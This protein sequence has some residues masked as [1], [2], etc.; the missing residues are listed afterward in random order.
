MQRLKF[1]AGV[2]SFIPVA[3]SYQAGSSAVDT[4]GSGRIA[5]RVV[6]ALTRT[7][8]ANA[9]VKLLPPTVLLPPGATVGR[10]GKMI[11]AGGAVVDVPR[12][13]VALSLR[14]GPD[15]SFEFKDVAPGLYE[16]DA[17]GDAYL[18][19][20]Q[21]TPTG[22]GTALNLPR[23]GTVGAV[24]VRLYKAA[25]IEGTLRHASGGPAVGLVVEAVQVS[26]TGTGPTL[27]GAGS[28]ATDD[29][30]AYRLWPLPPGR[31]LV[32]MSKRRPLVARGAIVQLAPPENASEKDVFYPGTHSLASARPIELS[33]GDRAELNVDLPAKAPNWTVSG[34]IV[35]SNPQST[36][37][38][39]S[40]VADHGNEFLDGVEIAVARTDGDGSFVFKGIPAGRYIV[41]GFILP[42][43]MPEAG[44]LSARILDTGR[45]NPQPDTKTPIQKPPAEPTMWFS[46]PISI[47][48]KPILDLTLAPQ[49][50][51]RITGRIKLDPTLNLSPSDLVATAVIARHG[52]GWRLDGLPVGRFEADGSFG[53]PALPPGRYSVLPY[54][55]GDWF[56]E[57]VL[58]NGQDVSGRG[59]DVGSQDVYN[60]EIVV[61][62][63][64]AQVTGVV[65]DDSQKPT[66][67]ATIV[68][69]PAARRDWQFGSIG[70]TVPDLD[71]KYKLT[72][73]AGAYSV[74]AVR[75]I[76][77][78]DWRGSSFLE[79]LEGRAS[80]VTI[81][82]DV[83]T[84]LDL[85][86]VETR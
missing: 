40:L 56:C 7:P 1:L 32:R 46:R 49:P 5:G 77:P 39:V 15:G 78:G 6:D 38:R 75:G 11:L 36:P 29:R 28:A 51:A 4:T 53:T 80:K 3:L 43:M 41:R 50:G 84:T 71:G 9:E 37:I 25:V 27:R 16:L 67:D 81:G 58:H 48:D 13:A 52:G 54:T 33:A 86:A 79:R 8:I 2:L 18:H 35:G 44:H 31:F 76:L 72:I 24:T 21:T 22:R 59:I 19:S 42:M 68:Y 10:G 47:V 34:Q 14:T 66:T 73:G 20:S 69:F 55:F 74:I 12:N 64:R 82:R 45:P 70:A 60:V 23:N 30:G 26:M 85:R 65:L 63:R 83:T 17:V 62:R 61:T 57:A